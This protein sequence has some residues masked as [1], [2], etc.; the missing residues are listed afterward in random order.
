MSVESVMPS[1]HLVLCRPL[2]PLSSIFP[3]ISA[4]LCLVTQWC[5][6]LCDPMDSSMPGSS[7]HEDSPGKNTGVGCHALLQGIFQTQGSN[8]DLPHY[9]QILCCLSNQ[10]SAG[11][12]RASNINS[13]I[14]SYM[15][16]LYQNTTQGIYC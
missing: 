13:L 5:S 6:T 4:L 9:R 10:G 8:L 3:S 15:N 12:Y 14:N 1:N 2:L 11:T 7:V 16:S